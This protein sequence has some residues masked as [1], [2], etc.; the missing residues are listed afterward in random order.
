ME[1]IYGLLPFILVIGLLMVGVLFWAIK[2]GQ[3]EDLEGSASRILMDEDD[4]L[5]PKNSKRKDEE[6]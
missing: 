5:L 6:D 3:Y 1:I 4:P 2:S